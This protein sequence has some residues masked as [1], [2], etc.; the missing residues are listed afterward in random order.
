M[1]YNQIKEVLASCLYS[2]THP[3]SVQMDQ[4]PKIDW[5]AVSKSL[6]LYYSFQFLISLSSS[7]AYLA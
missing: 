3:L 2:D 4:S 7:L 1:L 5:T 6:M